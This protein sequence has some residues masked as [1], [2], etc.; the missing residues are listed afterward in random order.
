MDRNASPA[1]TGT[2]ARHA[3]ESGAGMDRNPQKGWIVQ[4]FRQPIDSK[5]PLPEILVA[6][7]IFVYLN[8]IDGPTIEGGEIDIEDGKIVFRENAV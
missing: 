8:P 5:E 7:G 3:P 2:P 1:W 4:H 6:P